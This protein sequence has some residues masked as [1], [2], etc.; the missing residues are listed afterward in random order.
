MKPNNLNLNSLGKSY[1]FLRLFDSFQLCQYCRFKIQF[2][3]V[4]LTIQS[5]YQHLIFKL[6]WLRSGRL[7]CSN[8]LFHSIDSK[9]IGTIRFDR[10]QL[11]KYTYLPEKKLPTPFCEI[12]RYNLIK[13]IAPSPCKLSPQSLYG[14]GVQKTNMYCVVRPNFNIQWL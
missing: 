4:Q 5:Y 11:S 8:W 9:C 10:R 12:R 14:E 13:R 1:V 7:T 6:V 3:S 2:S